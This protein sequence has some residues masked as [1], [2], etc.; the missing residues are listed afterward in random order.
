[1]ISTPELIAG[2][3]LA[4]GTLVGKAE[5]DR[6]AEICNGC[7][8]RGT[9]DVLGAKFEGCTLCG[10]P[11]ATKLWAKWHPL[12]GGTVKCPAKKW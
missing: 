4:G 9:V 10:C 1:M 11:F 2:I 7:E 8:R 5:H 3:I 6:R 12:D